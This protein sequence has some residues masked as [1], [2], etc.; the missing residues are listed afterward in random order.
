MNGAVKR[1]TNKRDFRIAREPLPAGVAV[2]YCWVPRRIGRIFHQLFHDVNF[3][4]IVPIGI[5]LAKNLFAAQGGDAT[6]NPLILRLSLLRAEQLKLDKLRANE[7]GHSELQ[8]QGLTTQNTNFSELGRPTR[9][10]SLRQHAQQ[11]QRVTPSQARIGDAFA[12]FELAGVVFAGGEFLRAGVE[13]AFD[14][15]AEDL[16]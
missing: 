1:L 3:K 13:V 15:Q 4:I 14:H 2:R 8:R 9:L 10:N 5:D 11:L 7:R 16:F 6:G 12:V